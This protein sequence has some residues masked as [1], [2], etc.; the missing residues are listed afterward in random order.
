MRGTEFL[1]HLTLVLRHRKAVTAATAIKIATA[2]RASLTL[3]ESVAVALANLNLSFAGKVFGALGTYG[4]ITPSGVM[5]ESRAPPV[6]EI[7]CRK[8]S[9]ISRMDW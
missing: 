3:P 8:S 4:R 6:C 1:A 7:S 5:N 2:I 9:S